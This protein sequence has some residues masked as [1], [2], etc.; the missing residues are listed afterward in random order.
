MTAE[1]RAK[2]LA[3]VPEGVSRVRVTNAEGKQCYKAIPD[4]L[5]TDKVDMTLS[6]KPIVM[7][8]TPGRPQGSTKVTLP[9]VSKQAEEVAQAKDNHEA[10]S[11]LVVVTR[12]N[13]ESDA[14]FHTLMNGLAVEITSLEFER[15]EAERK[16]EDTSNISAKRVRAIKT[17]TDAWLKKRTGLDSGSI[18]MEGPAFKALFAFTLETVR[19]AMTDSGM[20]AEHIE[21]V[22]A[23]LSKRLAD[24]WGE[25]AKARMR[26]AT[27]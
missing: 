27:K 7:R 6:G 10:L 21:T 26:D 25:D 22:F 16:G 1:E 17:M 4:I 11:D 19:G 15:R 14:V 9:P 13:S 20:R 3:L 23:K 2:L 8:A 18:D 12:Q 5:D 24:G